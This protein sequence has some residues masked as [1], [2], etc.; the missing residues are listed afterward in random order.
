MEKVKEIISSITGLEAHEISM[1]DNIEFDLGFDSLDAIECIME[2]E[3]E[4]NIRIH[5]DIAE[6]CITVNDIHKMLDSYG[7]KLID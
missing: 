2:L 4:F 7:V 6:K 1:N 3:K 5:D